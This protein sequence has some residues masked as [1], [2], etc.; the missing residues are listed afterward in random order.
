MGRGCSGNVPQTSKSDEFFLLTPGCHAAAAA[1]KKA[2]AVE[3]A[4][5]AAVLEAAAAEQ[6]AAE[7]LMQ[8]A[9][10][11]LADASQKLRDAR[12]L[13]E[14]VSAGFEKA[15]RE[16]AAVDAAQAERKSERATAVQV[17]SELASVT[18]AAAAA[19]QERAKAEKQIERVEAQMVRLKGVESMLRA[20]LWDVENE[21]AEQREA[22]E[23][24]RSVGCALCH[25]LALRARAAAGGRSLAATPESSDF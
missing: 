22:W 5:A 10:A 16:I 9:T 7:K 25:P 3:R 8:T 18:A 19:E 14:S 23:R 6:H 1:E 11:K 20:E 21:Y 13:R 4:E 2:A 17:Q 15:A 24:E 12:E